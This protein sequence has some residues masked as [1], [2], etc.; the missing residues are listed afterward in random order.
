MGKPKESKPKSK[1]GRPKTIINAEALEAMIT[2]GAT[3]QDCAE[4]FRTSTD[5]IV[6]FIKSEWSMNFAEYSNKKQATVRIKLREAML[7][8][9]LGGHPTMMIWCSKNVL[10]WAE[11]TETKVQT[12]DN[13]A[14][15]IEQEQA[16]I[17]KIQSARKSDKR[18]AS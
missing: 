11:K 8:K 12:V 13:L 9:A 1:R 10:G 15:F 17:R 7:K 14:A 6:R 2:Y 16:E 3:C 4:W 18:N 5:T